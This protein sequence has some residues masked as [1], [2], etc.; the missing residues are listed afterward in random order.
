[1]VGFLTESGYFKF[2]CYNQIVIKLLINHCYNKN[3]DQEPPMTINDYQSKWPILPKL[4]V[5]VL[6]LIT[7]PLGIILMWIFTKWSIKSKLFITA[8]PFLVLLVLIVY[9]FFSLSSQR[10]DLKSK[11]TFNNAKKEVT[12]KAYNIE[13]NTTLKSYKSKMFVISIN[14]PSDWKYTEGGQYKGKEFQIQE[15]NFKED[16]FDA[17]G[18]PISID[19]RRKTN[20][21]ELDLN[22]YVDLSGDFKEN[23]P[24]IILDIN[25]VKAIQII[26]DTGIKTYLINPK[27][28][29]VVFSVWMVTNLKESSAIKNIDKHIE[30]YQKMVRTF[31]F[32]EE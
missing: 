15:V 20:N 17:I 3:M 28:K 14:Y 5:V 21:D 29:K 8:G 24:N 7:Y 26:G 30:T 9:I 27:D 6:L 31:K 1:M 2:C 4:F 18:Y 12:S 16:R 25:G 11:T 22:E 13:N 19:I 32:N 23:A 10:N